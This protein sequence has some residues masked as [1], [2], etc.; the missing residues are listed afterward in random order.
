MG[1]SDK[2]ELK[3]TASSTHSSLEFFGSFDCPGAIEKHKRTFQSGKTPSNTNSATPIY[4]EYKNK[5][6]FKN[7]NTNT[8]SYIALRLDPHVQ[9]R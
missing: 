6:N 9:Q 8:G 1:G 2:K 4:I 7:E 3:N 5:Y